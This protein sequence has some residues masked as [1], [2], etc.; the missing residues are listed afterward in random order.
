MPVALTFT[1]TSVDPASS[2]GAGTFISS[3][4]ASGRVLRKACMMWIPG[5]VD[6][7]ADLRDDCAPLEALGRDEGLDLIG[8][9]TA[10][11]QA[12]FGEGFAHALLLHH[13]VDVPIDP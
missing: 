11:D 6:A 10:D 7:D 4:P 3:R 2:S 9:A 1:S 13:L 8:R 5:S 12:L